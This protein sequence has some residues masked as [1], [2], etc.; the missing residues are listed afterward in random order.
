MST[1]FLAAP[2]L[3]ALAACATGRPSSR[4]PSRILPRPVEAVRQAVVE[5]LVANGLEVQEGPGWIDGHL[6]GSLERR[7][8]SLR[9]WTAPA[10]EGRT[11]LWVDQASDG[12]FAPTAGGAGF[13]GQG[14]AARLRR[15]GEAGWDDAPA[16]APE[17]PRRTR[18]AAMGG[19]NAPLSTA[20]RGRGTMVLTAFGALIHPGEAPFHLLATGGVRWPVL[21][22]TSAPVG[23]PL[24]LLAVLPARR[25]Q[26]A[27]GVTADVVD[28][29]VAVGGL[30]QAGVRLGSAAGWRTGSWVGPVLRLRLT[31]RP[32]GVSLD[33]GMQAV[34]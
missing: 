7:P 23:V 31:P 1:R 17:D 33:V 14:V 21:S 15:E 18:F 19:V 10:G 3:L 20:A 32:A 4:E 13:V 8:V 27:A 22:G 28:G 16:P 6:A 26:G 25:F 2:L 5:T 29:Q 30:L 11:A 12:A 34:F 24:D 9:V